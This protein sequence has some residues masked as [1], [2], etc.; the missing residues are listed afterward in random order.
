MN[1]AKAEFLQKLLK[2]KSLVE[3]LI[4]DEKPLHNSMDY[5]YVDGYEVGTDDC[6]Y[7]IKKNL[8]T[9]IDEVKYDKE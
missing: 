8:D 5:L 7:T 6:L 3:E 1:T 9:L 2:T 4:E